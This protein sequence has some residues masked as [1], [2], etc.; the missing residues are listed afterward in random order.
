[1][2]ICLIIKKDDFSKA[3]FGF[4]KFE[5]KCVGKKIKEEKGKKIKKNKK[6]IWSQ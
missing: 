2:P 1:M 5:G 4:R 3:M 6:F